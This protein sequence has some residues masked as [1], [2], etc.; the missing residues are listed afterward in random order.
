MT[1]TT[2]SIIATSQHTLACSVTWALH[3]IINIITLSALNT[4]NL[5]ICLIT[6]HFLPVGI[7]FFSHYYHDINLRFKYAK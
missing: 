5:P 6:K 2:Q 4:T 1:L 7:N 3:C